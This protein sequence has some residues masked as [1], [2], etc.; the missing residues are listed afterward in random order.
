MR[1]RIG[2]T[3]LILEARNQMARLTTEGVVTAI[4]TPT[5]SH[6]SGI[7]VRLDSGAVG[8]VKAVLTDRFEATR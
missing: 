7:R 2:D 4:L 8:R 5:P 1:P 3:V 6:P